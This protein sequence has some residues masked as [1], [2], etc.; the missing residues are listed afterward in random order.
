VVSIGWR[1][2][3]SADRHRA[4]RHDP[5]EVTLGVQGRAGWQLVPS[6]RPSYIRSRRMSSTRH[7]VVRG[8]SLTGRGK[9]P[10]LTPA[11]HVE[12]PIG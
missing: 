3:P 1:T 5:L 4:S 2:C 12:R 6:A 11:H 8:P 10:L 7:A 9:R